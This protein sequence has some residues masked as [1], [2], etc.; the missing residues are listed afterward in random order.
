MSVYTF[1]TI[2]KQSYMYYNASW[3]DIRAHV[4]DLLNLLKKRKIC[5]LSFKDVNM[6]LSLCFLKLNGL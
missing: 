4:F 3:D 6:F 5:F 2:I 1:L